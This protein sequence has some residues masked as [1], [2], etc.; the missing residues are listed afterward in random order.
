MEKR[1]KHVTVGKMRVSIG[2]VFRHGTHAR[3][4]KKLAEIVAMV[5]AGDVAAL[6]AIPINPYS[7]SPKTMARYRDLAVLALGT[8][9]SA[10]LSSEYNSLRYLSACRARSEMLNS[11]LVGQADLN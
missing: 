7:S 9:V 6:K 11:E 1:G 8:K 2:M 3:F 10:G 5:E 4:R